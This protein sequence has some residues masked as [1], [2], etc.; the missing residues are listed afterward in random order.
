[1][2]AFGESAFEYVALGVSASDLDG[3]LPSIVETAD[4]GP[5]PTP[6]GPAT[7]RISAREDI[8]R[9]FP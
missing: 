1:M 3:P 7:Q 2:L 5:H 4:Y 9:E 6:T 8:R